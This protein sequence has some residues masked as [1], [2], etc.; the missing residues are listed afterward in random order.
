[1]GQKLGLMSCLLSE[2]EL[3]ILD[4]PMTG[5]DPSARVVLKNALIDYAKS[6]KTVFFS[7]H[8]LDDIEEICDKIAVLHN[9]KIYFDGTPSEFM[10]EYYENKAEKAFLKCI[11]NR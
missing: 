9:G 6:G 1:M 5:L 4:E 2:A 3:L 8:I 7:S 11:N 10:K